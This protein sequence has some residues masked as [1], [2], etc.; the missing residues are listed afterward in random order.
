[1]DKNNLWQVVLGEIEVGM[2]PANFQTWFKNTA[3]DSIDIEKGV[4]TIRVPNDFTKSWLQKKYQKE[5]HNRLNKQLGKVV[6]VQYVVGAGEK[7]SSR[8]LPNLERSILKSEVAP[9][10]SQTAPR[11]G[12][13]PKFTFEQ[14]IVGENSKLC[15]AAAEAVAEKPGVNNNPLFIYGGVGLGKTHLM[16]AIGNQILKNN[17]NSKV[18]YVTSER[19]TNEMVDAI[20][21]KTMREFKEKYRNVDCLLIDDVQFLS[22]KEQT[23]EEF[24]HTFNAL[25]G[26][27]K[28]I[29]LTSD[30]PPKAIPALEKRLISRFICGMT[31]DIS[32]PSY[33][34]R[35]AIL[36]SKLEASQKKI[37]EDI[38]VYIARV[39]KDNVR[40]LEGALTRVL[41]FA[42]L[43]K[44]LLTTED[45]KDLLAGIITGPGRRIVKPS[46][47]IRAVASFFDLKKEELYGRKRT[48]EIVIPRQVLIYLLREELDLPY[49]QI[50]D[51][52]GGRDHTTIIH[53]YKKI[54]KLLLENEYL[55]D[56]VTQIKNKLYAVDK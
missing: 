1:M 56:Q 45:A 29:V 27:G 23:Q 22:G 5:I 24:F 46:E 55:V 43:N 28:Q 30:R 10:F 26:A 19:F 12:L 31:A 20:R 53:D 13:N 33:E 2:S 40:E 54:K 18:L 16:Q 41:A 52:L 8:P 42:E 39:V 17:P 14:F 38:L 36:H 25:Y 21:N 44:S 48:R 35:L 34:T 51:E 50:G 4:V 32:I 11:E 37:P 15:Y 47:I 49:K 9:A 6:M 7:P 3:I